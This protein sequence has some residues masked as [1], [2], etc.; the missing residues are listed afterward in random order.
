MKKAFYIVAVLL[1]VAWFLS[2]FVFHSGRV[3]HALLMLAITCWLHAVITCPQKRFL[4]KDMKKEQTGEP[5][6]E[7]GAPDPA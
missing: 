3:T 1:A 6:I 5:L 2:Y 7:A 4:L